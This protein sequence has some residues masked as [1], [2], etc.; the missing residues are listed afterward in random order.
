MEPSKTSNRCTE[1]PKIALYL[2][3]HAPDAAYVP[4]LLASVDGAFDHLVYVDTSKDKAAR[5]AVE[6]WAAEH[7]ADLRAYDLDEWPEGFHY[8]AAR[9]FA[10]TKAEDTAADWCFWMDLDD[11]LA[12]G[13]VER[14]RAQAEAKDVDVWGWVYEV[15]GTGK[16]MRERMTRP[17]HGA[18]RRRIHELMDFK[19]GSRLKPDN[20]VRVLHMP[21]D[22]KSNHAAHIKILW[23]E[24]PNLG[25]NLVYLAKEHK[26]S[27]RYKEGKEL[28]ELAVK[29]MRS[30]VVDFE[31][32][33]ELYN[34]LMDLAKIA[35]REGDLTEARAKFIEAMAADPQRREAY[36]YLAEMACVQ[37]EW[38]EALGWIRAANAQPKPSLPLLEDI[39]YDN[40]SL[41]LHWRVLA[42]CHEFEEAAK[43]C[44]H[45]AGHVTG[46]D[47]SVR[48][49][50]E[51]LDI[52]AKA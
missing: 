27:G 9:A 13:G 8:G 16:F 36:F 34:A 52:L 47:E 17:M 41:R 37:K 30:D 23:D 26:N 22:S 5:L 31:N 2:I 43:I 20:D 28:Y 45:F 4:Q 19:N 29:A 25:P 12:P 51:I 1:A 3:G 7:G 15:K 49:E 39:V 11:V 21:Q 6:Q 18:W 50:R 10:K 42:R 46:Q 14:I 48:N 32:I 40:Y 35:H 24:M 33:V 38:S 44:N